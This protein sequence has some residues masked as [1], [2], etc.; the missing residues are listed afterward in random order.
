MRVRFILITIVFLL[1]T[2]MGFGAL[3]QTALKDRALSFASSVDEQAFAVTND[4]WL[5]YEASIELLPVAMRLEQYQDIAFNYLAE[6]RVDEYQRVLSKYSDTLNKFGNEGHKRAQ[7]ILDAFELR[8]EFGD[9][10]AAI[11]R[12]NEL[13]KSDQLS[14]AQRERAK[15]ALAYALVDAGMTQQAEETVE[16]I[17]E[18]A[19]PESSTPL[20]T[21]EREDIKTYVEMHAGDFSSALMAM[22]ASARAHSEAGLP[23]DSSNMLSN[24][25]WMLQQSGETEAAREVAQN[26]S[27]AKS[28]AEA[29]QAQSQ[30][31]Q[32]SGK[33][34]SRSMADS[35]PASGRAGAPPSLSQLS[36]EHEMK[37]YVSDSGEG[38]SLSVLGWL[39]GGF[40]GIVVV[41]G[42]LSK[43]AQMYNPAVQQTRKKRERVVEEEKAPSVAAAPVQEE[44]EPDE[45]EVPDYPIRLRKIED[46]SEGMLSQLRVMIVDDD[47]TNIDVLTEFLEVYGMHEYYVAY[48]GEE[49]WS[50]AARAR[51]DLILMDI[52]MPKLNGI[53]ATKRI[54]DTKRGRSVPIIGVTAFSRVVN[55]QMCYDAGM[56]GFL[57]K[58]LDMSDLYKELKNALGRQYRW[59]AA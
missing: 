11:A 23:F 15:I 9:Y 29:R 3:A 56:N 30:Q 47:V 24:T 42:L 54:R 37:E 13:L 59:N 22:R 36:D 31:A 6:S 27:Q 41:I 2:G 38:A 35:T 53:D 58:P 49:A 51:V 44:E 18:D 45:L 50:I 34:R 46:P 48:N 17:R 26:M 1:N 10:H 19:Q 33:D 8:A 14:D 32:S 21:V 7:E 5:A 52:Q 40:V 57:T 55:E 43:L 4:D 12:L 39:A 20:A 25:V 16:E 28:N